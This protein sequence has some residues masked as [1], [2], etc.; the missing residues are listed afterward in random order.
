MRFGEQG[1]ERGRRAADGEAARG[2]QWVRPDYRPNL[3]GSDD[4]MLLATMASRN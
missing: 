1:S 2:L 4:V 3:N